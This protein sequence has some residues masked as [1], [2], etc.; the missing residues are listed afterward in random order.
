[1]AVGNVEEVAGEVLVNAFGLA[2]W[3][4]EARTLTVNG[5]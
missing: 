1:M 2:V 4:C 5:Q 3:M